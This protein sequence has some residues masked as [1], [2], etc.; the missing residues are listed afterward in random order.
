MTDE[1]ITR[2][3]KDAWQ[4]SDIGIA[5]AMLDGGATDEQDKQGGNT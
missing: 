5:F 2:I 3:V 4:R 1:Q